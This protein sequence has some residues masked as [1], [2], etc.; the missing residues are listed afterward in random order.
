MA[1][2]NQGFEYKK[3]ESIYLQARTLEEKLQ[4]L[5]EMIRTCPKHKSSEKMLAN[6]KTRY[7]KLK[8]KI[9]ESKKSGK[10]GRKTGIKKQG[11]QTVL[12][13]LTNSG[14]SSILTSL[15]NARPEISPFPYT[16]K[17]PTIGTLDYK[18]IKFQIIDLPS[19]E[20]ESFDQGIMNNADISLIVIIKIQE[21]D[22]ILPFLEKTTGK[23]LIIFN[24]ID[25][26]NDKEKRKIH[27][28]LKTKKL[29]FCLFSSKSKE[30]IGELRE[31]IFASANII[32]IYTKEPGKKQTD[33][34]PIILKPDSTV[35]DVARKIS[36]DLAKNIK[37]IRITGPSSK[38]SNQKVGLKHKIKDKDIV[39]F[40]TK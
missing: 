21:L 30:G 19:I 31:K 37:E 5:E 38:F 1:S 18:G 20:R 13:G 40:H 10:S 25:I 26:L 27:E 36:K 35:E 11:I 33:K 22:K 23:R 7:V 32:R 9:Q 8:S 34:E 16:T 17:N 29:K 14:K 39:E 2:T 6:L 3:A 15:T 4:A 24:K 28:T 12:V